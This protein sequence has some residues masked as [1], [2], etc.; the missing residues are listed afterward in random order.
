VATPRFSADGR[1]IVY[2]EFSSDSQAPFD[3][4][5]ALYTVQVG[6]SGSHL[7]VGKPR[8]LATASSLLLELGPWLNNRI[9][10]FYSD[11]SLYALDIRTGATATIVQTQ[12]YA[13]II[14]VV[15]Q[16]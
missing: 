2:V 5:N 7:Q 1:T 6:G 11:G 15:E 13:H 12:A 14:A 3:R 4:H 8:L 16:G 9:L 10:T